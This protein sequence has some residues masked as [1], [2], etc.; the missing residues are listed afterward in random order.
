MPNPS[1]ILKTIG[2]PH[3]LAIIE[4]LVKGECNVSTI[5]KIIKVSQP[6]LSQHLAKL[7][8]AGIISGR[9]KA[10]EIFYHIKDANVIRI[11]GI[12]K[13]MSEAA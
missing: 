9:R 13:E 10:R 5:N 4:M 11:M 2:N 8:K 12:A 1:T 7:R 3:R 6:M